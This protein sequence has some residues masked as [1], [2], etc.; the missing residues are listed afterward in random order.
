MGIERAI[1]FDM[2]GTTAKASLITNGIPAIE[3]GY[4]IGGEASGQPMQIPVVDIVEIGAGGGSIAWCDP[5][6][7]IHVGPKSAG[8]DPGPAAYGKGST[9]PVVTDANLVLGRINAERFLNGAMKLDVKAAERAIELKLCGPTRLGV[10]EAALGIVQIADAAMSLAVRAVS[11]KKGVDPRETAMIAFGG[12]GPLHAVAI[13]REIFI[14][15]VIIPKV[16]GTFSALGMLMASWRQ[17]FVRTLYG[18]LGSLDAKQVE[19]VFAE[20]AEAGKAQVARDGIAPGTADFSYLADLRYVGQEHTIAIPVRDPKLLSGDFAPLREAFDAEHDQRY[21]QAAPDERLEIVNV[22]L[23]VTAAR[24]DTLAERWLSEKWTPEAA[25]R[26]PMA[27]RHHRR[28]GKACSHSHRL[29]A[30]AAG[31]RQGRRPRRDRGAERHHIHSSGRRRDHVRRRPS[32][33]RR[34]S[35]TRNEAHPI[36]VEVVR[37]AIVAYADEMANALSKAAYNM[38]IYEVRDYCCGLIDTQARM[39]SQNRGGLPIFLAD[40][41][42]AVADGIARYGLKG[43]APGDVIIMNQ[44]E[45]CGQHLNNVVLYSPCFHGDELVGFAANRAHWVDIGG[46]RQGFGSYGSSDIYAEGIQMRSLKIYEAGKR[47]ETLWQIIRD[48]TRYPDSALGDMRAQIASC[49]LGARRYAELIARYGRET[50]EA[51]IAK[52][53]DQA[54]AAARAVVEKIP[55]GDY[56]A[57]SFL[58]NDGRTLDKPLRVKVKV[59]VRG[60][61]MTVDFSEMNPQVPGPLN[62]GRGGGI[63]GARVAFKALTS[64]D[65]DVNEGC[66]RPLEVVLP[67]GTMLTAKPPSAL[68]CGAS[69]CRP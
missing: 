31:R 38:M 55:D 41:G 5:T 30:V 32:H 49:Q 20:L 10:K 65:L 9:D 58:D 53:W 15:R 37:N 48:N 2:G 67:E 8:A 24:T 57:E 23:V 16:P 13:A 44:G 18:L 4:V 1:G 60:S 56:E 43:F 22:R 27:R 12:A 35:M 66:F 61:Q 6:G 21:G 7:G 52:V 47:N 19:A 26:R 64:P 51:C 17:D 25:G 11:V 14:P 36:T 39:I 59:R 33:H 50:V 62:S 68:G 69:R 54:E 46:V 45:V 40:L 3:D 63:A 34:E 42:V 29:A 28:S